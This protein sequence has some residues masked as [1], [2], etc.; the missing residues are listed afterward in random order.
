MSRRF[1]APS[2]E[3]R[4]S[5]SSIHTISSPAPVVKPDYLPPPTHPALARQRIPSPGPETY[6]ALN[7]PPP[8]PPPP[9]HP[10]RTQSP[11]P[12]IP[13]RTLSK[14][15][16]STDPSAGTPI[17]ISY[18]SDP[19]TQLQI[20][21][22]YSQVPTIAQPEP[23]LSSAS[24][25]L[26]SPDVATRVL[27][28]TPVASSG[29][30][31]NFQVNDEST[32]QRTETLPPY[33]SEPNLVPQTV[34]AAIEPQ[35]STAIGIPGDGHNALGLQNQGHLST[36]NLPRVAPPLHPSRQPSSFPL[37]ETPGLRHRA[38]SSTN[39]GSAQTLDPNGP[40]RPSLFENSR[41]G[42]GASVLTLKDANLTDNDLRRM[43]DAEEV[44][45]YLRLFA[46]RVNEVAIDPQHSEA[47]TPMHEEDGEWISVSNPTWSRVRN[48]GPLPPH[49][50]NPQT[51]FQY[52]AALVYP[53]VIQPLPKGYDTKRKFKLNR[54]AGAA[55]RLYLAAYPA[56]VPTLVHLCHL[57]TWRDP[58]RSAFWCAVFWAAWAGGFLSQIIVGRLL[59]VL[60]TGGNVTREE[61]RRRRTA[62]REAEKL[63]K[64]IEGGI[65][66]V[67][68]TGELGVWEVTK[69]V[70]GLGKK[71]GKKAKVTAMDLQNDNTRHANGESNPDD[72]SE[73][74]EDWKLM[75][76]DLADEV[77]DFHERVKNIF[78]HRRPELTR[79]YIILLTLLFIGT[80]IVQDTSKVVTMVMGFWFWFIPPVVKQLPK[81]P[82]P[83]ACA[84]TDAEVAMELISKRVERGERVVPE[85]TS[86]RKKN[87]SI[88]DPGKLHIPTSATP[89]RSMA[90]LT[91]TSTLAMSPSTASL[92]EGTS[93]DDDADVGLVVP[94]M[95]A[96]QED[97]L[98]KGAVRAWNW[99][100]K[101]KKRIDQ[102]RGVE[103]K[104]I[105]A[106]ASA[107]QSFPA[108][109]RS[110][111]GMLM[112][113]S[114]LL[115][116][117][118]LFTSSSNS[119]SQNPQDTR[120]VKV[121]IDHLR[122]VK[123]VSPGGLS[124][125]YA[126]GSETVEEKF[127]FVVGRDEAFA[128]LVGW[129][130]GRW[131]HV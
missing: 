28:V 12:P 44:E 86:R 70:T 56:Y 31:D 125:R 58:R 24:Q 7:R 21:T 5:T 36:T 75:L 118:P 128:T 32:L 127:L 77:A 64:A 69:L 92:V 87:K 71:K 129:G 88:G 35:P 46:S 42:S 124:V 49:L 108:Q 119:Q 83:F 17:S 37:I 101:T 41:R 63:G 62:A 73:D 25:T 81:L 19:S 2:V 6:G 96:S 131:K 68:V 9:S 50:A 1:V 74:M 111:P 91:D 72:Q 18:S 65:P 94:H 120:T 89:S 39:I 45:R 109:H 123:K 48:V 27:V 99:W 112:I 8:P 130:G 102:S 90:D 67:G 76:V 59:Y 4:S 30:V 23:R 22:I 13:N 97:K 14:T 3:S 78:L 114:T 122:G 93:S 15:V 10:S 113:S 57:C 11:A 126:L 115:T 85:R 38:H 107:D 34:P 84:P 116:F 40:A 51:L 52:I 106:Q 55:Q 60:W 95:S 110:R 29:I 121:D 26:V 103:S 53:Y 33:S 54:A 79:F 117:T 105:H 104:T 47:T 20:N 82:S 61:I 66:G 16:H 80:F 100:G 98:R 43:Y